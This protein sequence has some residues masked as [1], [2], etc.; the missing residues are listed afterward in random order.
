MGQILLKLMVPI[1]YSSGLSS[2]VYWIASKISLRRLVSHLKV[3]EF[4]ILLDINILLP[5][6][7]FSLGQSD[8]YYE[9][10]NHLG[11]NVRE[12]ILTNMRDLAYNPD[13]YSK[14]RNYEV[15][16]ISLTMII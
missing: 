16:R 10:I 1:P 12:K 5:G 11:D 13:L 7:C 3:T 15:T 9:N 2:Q 4:E 8:F 14:A 6:D